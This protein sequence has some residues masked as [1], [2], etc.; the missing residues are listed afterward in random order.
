MV[1]VWQLESRSYA[2]KT[3]WPSLAFSARAWVK[4]TPEARRWGRWNLERDW[5]DLGDHSRVSCAYLEARAGSDRDVYRVIGVRLRDLGDHS[6][7]SCA[8]LE[9]RA[10][11]TGRISSNWSTVEAMSLTLAK[12]GTSINDDLRTRPGGTWGLRRRGRWQ[13]R[14]AEKRRGKVRPRRERSETERGE[15]TVR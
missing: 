5:G 14:E 10:G 7:V 15:K 12:S 8:Y 1:A 3:S 9:A 13:R 6:R 2:R 4:E 11:S